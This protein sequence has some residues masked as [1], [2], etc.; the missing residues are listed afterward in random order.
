MIKL[1]IL[2]G[3]CFVSLCALACSSAITEPETAV[4]LTQAAKPFVIN[5]GANGKPYY[6]LMFN[7]TA[8][9]VTGI[10]HSSETEFRQNGGQFSLTI[11]KNAFPIAAPKCKSDIILRMPWVASKV[12]VSEKYQLYLAILRVSEQNKGQLPVAI[13]LNPYVS[14][15]QDKLVL[16]QCNVFFRHSHNHYIPNIKPL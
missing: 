5:L 9:N 4:V 16:E 1:R 8:Q 11:D 12:D 6:H 3:S 14:E 10:E 13:E 2:L 15:T 7:L